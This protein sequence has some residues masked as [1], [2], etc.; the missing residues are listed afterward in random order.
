MTLLYHTKKP[1]LK[2]K[3]IDNE[4]IFKYAIV[5]IHF[6]PVQFNFNNPLSTALKSDSVI[7]IICIDSEGPIDL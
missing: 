7:Y 5:Y 2:K 3:N 1:R 4:S 6:S